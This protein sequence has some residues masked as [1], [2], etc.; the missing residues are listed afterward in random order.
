[1]NP[2]FQQIAELFNVVDMQDDEVK[3][4]KN[5]A[6]G[7]TAEES[8]ELGRLRLGEG[9]YQNAIR[10]FKEALSQ[11]DTSDLTTMVDLAG[12]YDYGD[13]ELQ[14][15]RQYRK[16]L[17]QHEG[18]SEPHLGLSDLLRRSGRFR[19]SIAELERAIKAEPG[20]AYYHIKLAE[21]LRE[22][23]EP[24][25]ALEAAQY[26]VVVK[27]D[28]PFYHYWIGDLLIQMK[29]YEEALQSLRAAIELSPGDDFL[30]LRASIAFWMTD[31]KP[32]AIKAI[33]LASDLDTEKNVYH[34]L[35][36]ALL[37]ESGQIEEAELEVERAEQMDRYDRDIVGRT[38][39]A[40][41]LDDRGY[42]AL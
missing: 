17:K 14:A 32:E 1:M 31:R 30:Y 3:A 5:A 39:T 35:L 42:T 7:K 18:S 6:A 13:L 28:E 8:E 38:L 20:N 4:A 16:A 27:P 15:F 2:S 33:R 36:E 22:M 10:H 41:G 23:G 29:R 40:M 37:R 12:A 11:R 24:T 19:D 9:D 21:A 34:G 26:A 25:K